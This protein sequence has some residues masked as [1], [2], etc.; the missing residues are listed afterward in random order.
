MKHS[1]PSTCDVIGL[2]HLLAQIAERAALLQIKATF[3]NTAKLGTWGIGCHC[4]GTWTGITCKS[5][6]VVN[7]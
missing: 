6:Q 4:G 1:K 5:G 3:N 2:T 7:V